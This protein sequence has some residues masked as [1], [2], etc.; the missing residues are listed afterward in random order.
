MRILLT[1]DD[2]IQS[3]GLFALVDSLGSLKNDRGEQLHEIWVVAPEHE[4]SG[5]SHAMTL[6][7]P[8]KLRKL[9]EHRYSCSGTPADCVIV[10][11]LGVLHEAPN[12]VISG[13]NKGPNLGTDI[14]YSGTCGAARQAALEGI[15]AI[16]VSC[17]SFGDSLEYGGLTSFV[18]SNLE[19]LITLWKPDSF[20]NI[21]GPS[22]SC[23]DLCAVWA[24][25]GK[26][27]YLDNLK[28]FDG[29]DGYTYCFLAEGRQERTPDIYSDHHAVSQGFIALSLVEIHPRALHDTALNGTSVFEAPNL[30][31]G[32]EVKH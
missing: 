10:A 14:I 4:R 20:I 26:N 7:K 31:S 18:A 1:N 11:G 29:A 13:I 24:N 12:V 17:A 2:G 28:C 5:V 25:P 22:T 8:T 21:N 6:K 30:H 32:S 23:T 16:A 3:D 27:R 15:P 19:K 9:G